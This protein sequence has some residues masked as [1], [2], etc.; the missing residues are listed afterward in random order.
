MSISKS[1]KALKVILHFLQKNKADMNTYASYLELEKYVIQQ[2][3]IKNRLVEK[4]E[5]LEFKMN[6]LDKLLHE[7]KS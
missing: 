2:S 7:N 6:N 5:S 4:I 3:E 1:N